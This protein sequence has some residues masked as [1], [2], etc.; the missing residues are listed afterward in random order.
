[1]S[2][3]SSR[4]GLGRGLSALLGERAHA[5]QA[6]VQ[7]A[8]AAAYF[9][10]TLGLGRPTP[11]E[12]HC[13]LARVRRKDGLPAGAVRRWL[14]VLVGALLP[15]ALHKASVR[16]MAAARRRDEADYPLLHALVTRLDEIHAACDRL[17]LAIFFLGGR[18]LHPSLLPSSLVQ[19]PRRSHRHPAPRPAASIPRHTTPVVPRV[20]RCGTARRSRRRATTPRSAS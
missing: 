10:L 7:A 13:D 9:G 11:G 6:E 12:E 18:Y 2:A 1:M 20:R 19:A 17:R 4:R 15:F 5:W 16:L 14:C 8:A 3:D